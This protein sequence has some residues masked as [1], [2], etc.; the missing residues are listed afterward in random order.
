MHCRVAG[1]DTP[2]A[3]HCLEKVFREVATGAWYICEKASIAHLVVLW[4]LDIAAVRA[5]VEGDWAVVGQ[6]KRKGKTVRLWIK[7]REAVA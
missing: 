7:S 6:R 3:A 5:V 2:I 1:R 4:R